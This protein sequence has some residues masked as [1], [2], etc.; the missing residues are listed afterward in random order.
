MNRLLT[1]ALAFFLVANLHAQNPCGVNGV[2]VNTFSF[3]YSPQVLNI[4]PGETVVWVNL[5]GNHNAQGAFNSILEV[6]FDNPE[7]FSFPPVSGNPNGVCIGSFTFT[8]PGVYDYD[9]SVGTHALAGMVGQIIVGSPGCT[10]PEAFNYDA[11]A[12]FD[13]GSCLIGGCTDPEA[14]NYDP[15]AEVD[16]GTCV[17][18][19]CTYA[20][21]LN[22]NPAATDDDGSCVFD[23]CSTIEGCTDSSACNYNIV[24]TIDDDSCDYTCLGCTYLAAFNYD[25]SATSDDGSCVFDVVDPMCPT[26]LN[27]DGVTNM[28]DL[29][30]MLSSFGQTCE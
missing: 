29:L 11:D 25:A 13:D 1:L 14:D 17:T 2:V 4:E 28:N 21:A 8:I 24:A 7:S 15:T 16:D 6:P 18:L 3:G 20:V 19:G 22:Y 9:C 26:D 23:D 30:S 10:D 12:D 5:G 27:N